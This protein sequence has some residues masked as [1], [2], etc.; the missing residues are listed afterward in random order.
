M[1]VFINLKSYVDWMLQ[2][3]MP[4][5]LPLDFSVT[6]HE[7]L[8]FISFPT[9]LYL[10]LHWDYRLL[11]T[12]KGA[13]GTFFSLFIILWLEWFVPYG[14]VYEWRLWRVVTLTNWYLGCVVCYKCLMWR[15]QGFWNSYFC[16]HFRPTLKVFARTKGNA[17]VVS[18]VLLTITSSSMKCTSHYLGCSHPL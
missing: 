14:A 3:N 12:Q 1:L 10:C 18:L 9:Y 8:V 2:Y 5:N 13:K 6:H 16:L 7:Q 15:E 11:L 17:C 4:V